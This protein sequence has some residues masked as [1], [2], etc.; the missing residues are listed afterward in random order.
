MSSESDF[1]KKISIPICL[2]ITLTGCALSPK[3]EIVA[4][5]ENSIS[6]K[7]HSFSKGG[8]SVQAA[9][10]MA[11]D[12]CNKFKKTAVFVSTDFEKDIFGVPTDYEYTHLF[13][14]A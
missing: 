11:D 5:N 14:C 9:Q 4:I 12:Y 3:P 8:E 10:K 7:D 13:K 2:L 6:I 1:M